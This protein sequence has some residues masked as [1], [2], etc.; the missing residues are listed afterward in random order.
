DYNLTKDKLASF[1]GKKGNM[2]IWDCFEH[3]V[4]YTPKTFRK[5]AD[6]CGFEIVTYFIPLPIHSPIWANLTGHYFQYPSPFILDWKRILL[7][8]AFYFA[9]RIER[10]FSDK[11]R[12]GPD[13][14]FIIRKKR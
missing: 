11:I 13:L 7:R 2:D 10:V 1:S 9:G 3:V 6:K 5:M 12:F 8:N 14:M 4:H